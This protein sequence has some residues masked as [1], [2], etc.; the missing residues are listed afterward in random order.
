MYK[1]ETMKLQEEIKDVS[2]SIAC[3]LDDIEHDELS[4]SWL[5]Q[6]LIKIQDLLTRIENNCEVKQ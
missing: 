2:L 5:E 4:M 6:D 3:L 1:G